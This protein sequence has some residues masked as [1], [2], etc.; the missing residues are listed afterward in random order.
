MKINKIEKKDGT[1]VYRTNVYLGVDSLTGKQVRTTA[2]GKTQKM[3]K[4]KAH[5]AINKFIENGNTTAREKI[6]FLNFK[7]LALSWLENYKL[8]I[9]TNTIRMAEN[10]FNVYIIPALGSFKVEKITTVLLQN[11]VNKWAQ[12]ANSSIIK[13]GKREKGKG[14]NYKLSL[15]YVSRILDYG[16]Q[17]GTLK[18]NVAKQVNVPK[19]KTRTINKIKYFENDEIKKFLLY[20][21]QL[22]PSVENQ[23]HS[24]LYRLL[25]AT[26][27][28]VGEALALNWS[29]I[30]FH[31]QTITV[32]KTV[33]RTS[34]SIIQ[35]GAKSN[36]SNRKITID[37][38][39]LQLLS[40]WKRRQN[41]SLLILTDQIVFSK[42]N[43]LC[44]YSKE[45]YELKKHLKMANVPDIGFHGFRHTHASLLMNNDVN[46]KEI[47]HRLGHSDY[48]ITMNTYSHLAKNKEKDTAR[49][50]GDILNAL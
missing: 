32:N 39:T 37:N 46:P 3:C 11:V 22:E 30:D 27:L 5:Q 2:T 43:Q 49:K 10:I 13:N 44:S 45:I 23:L 18:T 16:V 19:L 40:L 14:K 42:N 31:E 6:I 35:K 47:Q 48:G 12:N 26:G 9:K 25:L 20:L 4:M 36:E 7:E 28:R 24:C 34:K 29:D 41:N 21:E 38:N 15:N 1:T 50:F 8:S 17:V 33:V